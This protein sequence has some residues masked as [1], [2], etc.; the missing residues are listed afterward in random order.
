MNDNDLGAN[1]YH[2]LMVACEKWERNRRIEQGEPPIDST[3]ESE[4]SQPP[5]DTPERSRGSPAPSLL[6]DDQTGE[7]EGCEG[8]SRLVEEARVV[9]ILGRKE[10]WL[11]SI[12]AAAARERAEGRR[13]GGE[14]PLAKK[15]HAMFTESQVDHTQDLRLTEGSRERVEVSESKDEEMGA[16]SQATSGSGVEGTPQPSQ[17]IGWDASTQG[18]G[19]F[20][21]ERTTKV[22][23]EEELKE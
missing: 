19:G 8:A 17:T 11:M 5:S 12:L 1:T 13:Q 23:S 2:A 15:I 10:Q 14:S 18:R 9:G 20:A 7:I 4:G 6:Q 21:G 16:V 22:V 3:F